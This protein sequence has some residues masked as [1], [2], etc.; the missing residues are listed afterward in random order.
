MAILYVLFKFCMLSV[1]VLRVPL[2]SSPILNRI[3]WL[4]SLVWIAGF[5]LSFF[6]IQL[7]LLLNSRWKSL[8]KI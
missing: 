8:V 6:Y 2:A 5:G 1:F 4:R 7:T 3:F